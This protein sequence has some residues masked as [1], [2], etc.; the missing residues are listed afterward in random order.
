[1]N[2][3]TQKHVIDGFR[4]LDGGMND[5]VSPQLL[6]KNQ[7]SYAENATFSTGFARN[8]TKFQLITQF[9]NT[10][11]DP[12]YL[13]AKFQGACHYKPDSG[14]ES[15][16][17]QIGGRLLQFHFTTANS[18]YVT[19]QSIAGDLNSATADQ[20]WL[21]QSERWVICNDGLALPIFWDGSAMATTVR[22]SDGDLVT[23]P[24]LPISR[25]GAY[26]R[27]RN[28][29]ALPDGRSF[30]AGDI[31]NWSSGTSTY[32]FRDAVLK[33]SANQLISGG[34]SF[35]V[36]GSVGNI[37]GMKF[38][39][40]L[41]TSLGQGPLQVLTPDCVFTCNTPVDQSTWQFTTNPILTEA[42]IGYGGM[43]Q[44]STV[45]ANGD[46]YFRSSD[47]IRS[48]I[49]ARREFYSVG[50][51]LMSNEVSGV[52]SA[53]DQSLLKYGSGIFFDNRIIMTADPVQG[54]WGVYHDKMVV[55]DTS[56]LASL[57]QKASAAYDGVWTD[58]N[59][60]QLVT[61][62]IM[63]KQRAFAF[64][65]NTTTGSIELWEILNDYDSTGLT[66][67]LV[68]EI[69]SP[70]LFIGQEQ[71]KNIFDACRLVDGE[72]YVDELV[73][74]TFFE[75][76]YRSDYDTNWH[77]WHSW[78]VPAAIP[79]AVRMG[80]GEPAATANPTTGLPYRE[81]YT[82]QV[83]IRIT[84]PCQIIACKVAAV[85]IPQPQFAKPL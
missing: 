48:I 39:S 63:G 37:T 19:D 7:V 54:A 11:V 49:N 78:T 29:V 47:G 36:P 69:E 66:D 73:G 81:G 18:V 3:P 8:R 77:T 61:G 24:E 82:F 2:P 60:L 16:L 15:L 45:I 23:P 56:P 64:A 13:K 44:N 71:T 33:V 32:Q 42:L 4:T 28:W 22:R 62:Q 70:P 80:L 46:M 53:D 5:G 12:A 1:M 67:S 20:A 35:V 14:N 34:G 74:P 10:L 38:M 17:A 76:F 58:L 27:G 72:I 41:D 52:L 83:K 30:I 79:Y 9:L 51:T 85:V 65:W 21:W 40:I 26:G 55:M 68:W 59:V 25:M 43:S 84:G 31:V 75:T 6:K 50:N 57:Q